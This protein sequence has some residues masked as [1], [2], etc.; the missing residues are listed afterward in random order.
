MCNYCGVGGHGAENFNQLCYSHFVFH[1][2]LLFNYYTSILANGLFWV[3]RYLHPKN[4][5]FTRV[6]S[7]V[8]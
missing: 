4:A 7:V 2:G 3:N 1:P 6:K 8:F 5:Q